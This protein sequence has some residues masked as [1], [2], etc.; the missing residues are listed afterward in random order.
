MYNYGFFEMILVFYIYCFLGWFIE[1]TIVTLKEKR[2][3]SRG[4][5]RLPI[6]P[7]YG[8][9][10]MIIILTCIPIRKRHILVYAIC[11]FTVVFVEYFSSW[12]MERKFKISYW[13]H[14]KNRFNINGR[15][16]LKNS[17]FLWIYSLLIVYKL[18][19]II[20]D[21]LLSIDSIEINIIVIILTCVIVVDIV[22][23]ICNVKYFNKNLSKIKK[24]KIDIAS[25]NKD[26]VYA[27]NTFSYK[28][29]YI[30]NKK[31]KEL[32]KEYQRLIKKVNLF[33]ENLLKFYPNAK[34][35]NL[36]NFEEQITKK[37]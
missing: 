27:K 12:I 29:E 8:V 7:I 24:I 3:I 22:Y 28:T 35:V 11:L 6:M 31:S 21:M 10:S 9:G 2:L 17:V 4:F 14:K 19:K 32:H 5:L 33:Y 26:A 30:L 20:E 36:R 15:V 37:V 18:N 1:S 16:C 13:N 34:Y 25:I 23:S